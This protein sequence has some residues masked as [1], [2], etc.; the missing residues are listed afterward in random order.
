MEKISIREFVEFVVCAVL[1]SVGN[2][3]VADDDDVVVDN[4]ASSS[5][6]N[7]KLL[8]SEVICNF[9]ILRIGWKRN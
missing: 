5:Q 8:Q 1:R 9:V 3:G 6:L 4:I 2:G 7:G